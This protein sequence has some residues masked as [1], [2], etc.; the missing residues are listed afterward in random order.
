MF[1]TQ[2]VTMITVTAEDGEP[3]R[4]VLLIPD[5]TVP[6]KLFSGSSVKGKF[7]QSGSGDASTFISTV[8]LPSADLAIYLSFVINKSCWQP[9]RSLDVEC[10]LK[11]GDQ[12]LKYK[13]R[14]FPGQIVPSEAKYESTPVSGASIYNREGTEVKVTQL[15]ANE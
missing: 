3:V 15:G 6:Y 2:K 4:V 1:G 7:V 9:L 5:L 14:Q 13:C 12:D 8:S 10:R 11:K